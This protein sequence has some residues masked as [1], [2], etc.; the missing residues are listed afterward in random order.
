MTI[1][2][3]TVK[4]VFSLSISLKVEVAQVVVLIHISLLMGVVIHILS[5]FSKDGCGHLYFLK[6]GGYHTTLTTLHDI[7]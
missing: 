3:N 2:Y 5:M 6:G 7:Y 4:A 1:S